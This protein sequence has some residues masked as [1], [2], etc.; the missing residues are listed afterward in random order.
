MYFTL[1]RLTEI[2]RVEVLNHFLRLDYESRSSRFLTS[3]N[4][5]NIS[6]Y[7]KKMDF[8]NGI[9]GLFNENLEII[10]LGECIFFKYKDNDKLT[11]EVAFT[12]EKEYQGNG[13]GNKL[14]KI[15]VH[16]ANSRD[17]HELQMY[18][19]RTN[20][21]ILHLAKKYNLILQYEG[22]EISSVVKT[23]NILPFISTMNERFEDNIETFE[24][25]ITFQQKS[26]E[27]TIRKIS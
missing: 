11:A 4:D 20:Q 24:L 13:F 17:V 25:E 9:F 22:T 19:I 3:I 16:Y 21:A 15:V 10:G 7:V 12:V 18:C 14:M 26:Y 23:T 27:R 6:N 8:K 1:K 2:N 5:E